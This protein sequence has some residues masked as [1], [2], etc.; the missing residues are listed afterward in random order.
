MQEV[1][2]NSI[3]AEKVNTILGE[4]PNREQI[5]RWYENWTPGNVYQRQRR[6]PST[7]TEGTKASLPPLVGSGKSSLNDLVTDEPSNIDVTGNLGTMKVS[8]LLTE[9]VKIPQLRNRLLSYY[10][11]KKE[12]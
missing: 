12:P 2:R 11:F 9:L 4:M 7:N 8:V 1:K 6:L 10:I 3:N 5:K